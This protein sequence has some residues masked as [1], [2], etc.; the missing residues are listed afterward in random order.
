MLHELQHAVT[1]KIYD[2][3]YFGNDVYELAL[4][5]VFSDY[6]S[7]FPR[8]KIRIKIIDIINNILICII[9]FIIFDY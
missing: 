5:E 7:C 6:F 2:P 4:N 3:Y 9:N 8:P 1:H